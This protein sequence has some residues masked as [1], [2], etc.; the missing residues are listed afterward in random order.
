MDRDGCASVR[1]ALNLDFTFVFFDNTLADC[2][3]QTG[4]F[5]TLLGGEKC[6]EGLVLHVL[7][8]TTSTVRYLDFY[9]TVVGQ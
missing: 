4:A 9:V 3:S 1:S 5:P 6:L 7:I 8:H 2:Q